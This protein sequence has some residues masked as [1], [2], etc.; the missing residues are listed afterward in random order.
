MSSIVNQ[1]MS[2]ETL[3][4]R[5]AHGK[6]TVMNMDGQGKSKGI[7][8]RHVT[9]NA[10][11]IAPVIEKLGMRPTV[12]AIEEHVST[13][14]DMARPRGKARATCKLFALRTPLKP[15]KLDGPGIFKY[16]IDTFLRDYV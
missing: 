11:V 9:D 7:K 16:V 10:D 12:D 5:A 15:H 2:N 6:L 13:F 4:A 1:W 8:R 3:V 14:F